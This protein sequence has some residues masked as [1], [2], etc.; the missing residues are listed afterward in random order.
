M[1]KSENGFNDLNK[2]KAERNALIEKNNRLSEENIQLYRE[3]ERLKKDIKYIESIARRDFGMIGK[4]E[5]VIK[6]NDKSGKPDEH[7]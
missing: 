6:M 1:V 7:R 2:L 5:V 3:I 4:D